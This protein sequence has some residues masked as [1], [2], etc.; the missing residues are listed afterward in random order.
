[1]PTLKTPASK[2]VELSGCSGQSWEDA[3]RRAVAAGC[4]TIGSR[5]I[6][7]VKRLEALVTD[8]EIS[9]FRVQV[10]V[11]SAVSQGE[12]TRR[13]RILVVDDLVLILDFVRAVL[14]EVGHE[15]DTASDGDQA[16]A[17]LQAQPYDLVLMD[18]QMPV[19]DGI[20]ATR[21]I[22]NLDSS[23]RET[24]ILAMTPNVLPENIR[25]YEAV[26]MN[27]FL[28]KPLNRG[29]LLDK[30]REWL[31]LALASELQ[32]VSVVRQFETDRV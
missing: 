4:G 18:I 26:G 5:S 24:P 11:Q 3:I 16:L 15:V 10:E 25:A 17:M 2:P 29:D 19:M 20:A 9:Q 31:P 1:V 22:R 27:D 12:L 6:V 30:L 21:A 32:E 13:G 8:G 23:A 14:E 7:Q 28:R